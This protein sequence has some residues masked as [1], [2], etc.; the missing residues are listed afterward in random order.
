MDES[1]DPE[2]LR[3][4]QRAQELAE[5]EALDYADRGE[6]AHKHKRRAEKARY[7]REKLE[8]QADADKSK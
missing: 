8:Q 7:L 2:E 6:D 4:R 1:P 5:R 3:E